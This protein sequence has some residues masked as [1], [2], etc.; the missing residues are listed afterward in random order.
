MFTRLLEM[1]LSK[2]YMKSKCHTELVEV[3]LIVKVL[4][5]FA[6]LRQNGVFSLFGK[7]LDCESREQGSIPENTQNLNNLYYVK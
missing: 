2:A 5:V 4:L 7:V 6:K 1:L 3:Q